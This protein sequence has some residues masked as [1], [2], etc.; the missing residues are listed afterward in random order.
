MCSSQREIVPLKSPVAINVPV[1]QWLNSLVNA[2]KDSLR[3]LLALC[4]S[5]GNKADPSKY[6]SQI[7]C[8]TESVQFTSKCENAIETMTLPPL[9][10]QYKVIK[11][12]FRQF[13]NL[14]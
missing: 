1:E 12:K 3:N 4:L 5:E 11:T 8:L 6:P 2:M 7:L 14:K 9:L 10:A 13:L